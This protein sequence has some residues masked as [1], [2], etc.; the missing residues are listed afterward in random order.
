MS[1]Y[2]YI[3]V[4]FPG[5]RR[6]L[7]MNTEHE[8]FFYS[9]PL[10][11]L[12]RALFAGVEWVRIRTALTAR[13]AGME[14]DYRLLEDVLWE[15]FTPIELE[16]GDPDAGYAAASREL[17]RAMLA[18]QTGAGLGS[19]AATGASVLA[20]A[21]TVLR[22][23]RSLDERFNPL[24]LSLN[25]D[26]TAPFSSVSAAAVLPE[27]VLHATPSLL[28]PQPR[29]EPEEPAEP[30]DD[31]IDLAS[32]S[33]RSRDREFLQEVA[34]E[35]L[36][37]YRYPEFNVYR[38]TYQYQH[39]TLIERSLRASGSDNR[40]YLQL[41]RQY[42]GVSQR[43]RKRFLYLQP[44][45]LEMSRRWLSGDD[46]FL[47]DAVDFAIDLRRGA[48]PD[49]KIYFQKQTNRRD[50]VTVLLVDSS[51]STGVPL[52]PTA[53]RRDQPERQPP[54]IIEVEQAALTI[55]A[56]ALREIDD[57]FGV[58]SFFSLG[59]SRVFFNVV[60]DFHEPWDQ[61]SQARVGAMQP[62]ASNR[63][64]C[65]IRHATARL[66]QREERTKLLLLSDGIPADLDY[67][68]ASGADTS[69]YTIED[70]RRAIVEARNQ[71]V[72]AFCLTIDRFARDYIPRLYG[73]RQ[74]AMLTDVR[75]LPDKLGQLY[76]RLTR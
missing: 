35:V 13:Y 28:K 52:R 43:L 61:R 53:N 17:A 41:L 74:Y 14:E 66:L 25:S 4:V 6:L 24:R 57:C 18:A 5:N 10:P 39:Y 73:D 38:G 75:R 68:G 55:A 20:T 46:I 70:T 72:V 8:R 11:A 26:L 30:T 2:V 71:G 65:A 62:Y 19:V 40:G 45:E 15:R 7:V 49:E 34:G 32:L 36:R 1:E 54:S 22:L 48:S 58:F 27:T 44:E 23:Y 29:P 64:G 59:R 37:L 60:K 12:A 69:L 42:R 56:A 31:A 76:L 33:T 67:G 50:L 63:D 47:T 51:S 21:E 9:F 16:Q 3:E